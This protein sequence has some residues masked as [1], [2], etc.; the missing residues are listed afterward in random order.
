MSGEGRGWEAW[1]DGDA[2]RMWCLFVLLIL[3]SGDQSKL[4]L[5]ACALARVGSTRSLMLFELVLDERLAV[6]KESQKANTT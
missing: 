3:Y 5:C 6:S 4:D 1:V 2:G